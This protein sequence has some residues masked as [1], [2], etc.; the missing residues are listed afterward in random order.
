MDFGETLKQIREA[1]HLKQSDIASGLLHALR[2][3]KSRITSNIPL[4]IVHLNCSQML[5]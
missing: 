5:A 2:S 4:M 1:R 3:Q